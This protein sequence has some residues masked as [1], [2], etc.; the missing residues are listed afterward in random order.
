[1]KKFLKNNILGGLGGWVSEFFDVYKKMLSL[2][3]IFLTTP[4]TCLTLLN[5]LDSFPLSAF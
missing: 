5:K 4:P 2:L 1:M 3:G